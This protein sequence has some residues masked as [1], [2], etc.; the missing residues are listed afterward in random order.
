MTLLSPHK[1]PK[2]PLWK[3]S[4]KIYTGPEE[5]LI[6]SRKKNTQVSEICRHILQWLRDYMRTVGWI[7]VSGTL[8]LL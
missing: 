5:T 1:K 4:S 3:I 7:F 2:E 6:K 8:F